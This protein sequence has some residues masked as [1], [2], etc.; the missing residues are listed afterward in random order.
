MSRPKRASTRTAPPHYAGLAS[1]G[2]S[3]IPEVT[4]FA[5]RGCGRL[6]YAR[7]IARAWPNDGAPGDRL[8]EGEWDCAGIG[9]RSGA[10]PRDRDRRRPIRGSRWKHQKA[11]Q[12]FR[13]SRAVR[14]SKEI[15]VC[16]LLGGDVTYVHRRLWP[17]LV[18]LHDQFRARELAAI[19]EIHT[20]Q[21]KHKLHVTDFPKWVPRR[22]W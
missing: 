9:A 7:K 22:L 20:D 8:R 17:A 2:G 10:Q 19:R 16:R 15:L 13:C 3:F 21:G 6:R 11:S 14:D 12:I 18:N 4:S 1:I 5:A